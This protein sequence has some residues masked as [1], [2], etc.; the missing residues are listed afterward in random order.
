MTLTSEDV[1][2]A[3]TD[4]LHERYALQR[5]PDVEAELLRRHDRLAL[6]VAN[7]FAGRGEAIE[8]L[9]QVARLALWR[10]LRRFEPG[11][12]LRFST[13][14]MP[15]IAGE[16][17]R[18][19][20]DRTWL[21]RPPRSVQE[22]YLAV[23]AAIDELECD[24]AHPSTVAELAAATGDS[25][26]EVTEALAA[27][28]AR[29]A[30]ISLDARVGDSD[31]FALHDAIED[32]QARAGFAAAESGLFLTAVLDTVPEPGRSALALRYVAK[33]S[34]AEIADRLGVSQMT[35]SRSID[36]A[37]ERLR[38]RRIAPELV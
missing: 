35:V 3:A 1:A 34:Q 10:A 14:A 13:F 26:E 33:L 38:M 36:R 6:S 30:T 22:R 27:G 5:D 2:R 17:K 16:L 18:H 4:A 25:E 31:D 15:T 37:L 32:D 19:F 28:S 29:R 12:G 20:R 7:R 11:R 9:E 8:D 23:Q 24:L 21:V